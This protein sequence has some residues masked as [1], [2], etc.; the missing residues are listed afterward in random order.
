MSDGEDPG[1]CQLLITSRPG[2]DPQI[3]GVPHQFRGADETLDF[4]T[5]LPPGSVMSG[6]VVSGLAGDSDKPGPVP[7]PALP[8]HPRANAGADS[9]TREKRVS[10][11][12]VTRC[13]DQQARAPVPVMVRGRP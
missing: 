11:D 13:Q 1:G 2:A 4:C 6:T 9:S 5:L 8:R 3:A 12:A 7:V 10:D